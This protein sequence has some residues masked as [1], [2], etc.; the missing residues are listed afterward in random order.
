MSY[1][2]GPQSSD[3]IFTCKQLVQMLVSFTF[4]PHTFN[5]FHFFSQRKQIHRSKVLISLGRMCFFFLPDLMI[6]DSKD[7]G[8][9]QSEQA[10]GSLTFRCAP[11]KTNKFSWVT[12][13]YVRPLHT[14][15]PHTRSNNTCNLATNETNERKKHASVCVFNHRP[16]TIYVH[17]PSHTLFYSHIPHSFLPACLLTLGLSMRTI[18]RFS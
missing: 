13:V 16:Y 18:Y 17:V 15:A 9:D 6:D 11:S 14:P 7:F 2:F 10:S 5:H 4:I 12:I 3:S 1:S 8:R